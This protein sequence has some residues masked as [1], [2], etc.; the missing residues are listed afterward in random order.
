MWDGKRKAVTFSYDDGIVQDIRLVE[1][2]NR[3]G[4][5]C[6]FN[7]NS[8]IM[9][10][11]S[12]WEYKGTPV[13]R[14][15]PDEMKGLYDGHEIAVHCTTHAN[16]CGLSEQRLAEE[17]LEDRKRLEEQF[18]CRIS[19]MAYPYGAY[20][21]TVVNYLRANG[22]AYGRTVNGTGTT[23]LPA[24]DLLML[25]PT[26][27]HDRED[28]FDII[29]RFLSGEETQ[30]LY[31]WGH[32]YEFDGNHNWDRLEEICRRLSGR[33]DVFY[34]TNRQVLEQYF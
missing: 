32:S 3:Y 31:I 21:E 20:D 1:I 34:G 13:R 27:H 15:S 29:D 18:S 26:A 24:G 30:L 7:L 28:L 12:A 17:I 2:L 23:E 4:I 33:E 14:L 11:Q 22:F 5:K 10:P 25:R 6:T 8:G 9:G 19:G 16:L